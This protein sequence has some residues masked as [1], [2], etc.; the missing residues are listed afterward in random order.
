MSLEARDVSFGYKRGRML[1]EGVSL[2]VSLVSAS[3]SQLRRGSARRRC[4]CFSPVICGLGP[5][6]CSSTARPIRVAEP[7]ACS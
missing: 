6:R 5:A 4:A 1:Y 3:P 7:R 2:R